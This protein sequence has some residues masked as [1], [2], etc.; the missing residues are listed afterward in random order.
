MWRT[1]FWLLFMRITNWRRA[2]TTDWR[3]RER[4]ISSEIMSILADHP[5]RHSNHPSFRPPRPFGFL[6]SSSCEGGVSGGNWHEFLAETDGFWHTSG[7][8]K[9]FRQCITWGDRGGIRFQLTFTRNCRLFRQ[10]QFMSSPRRSCSVPLLSYQDFAKTGR[11]SSSHQ[12]HL[13]P[14]GRQYRSYPTAM[15]AT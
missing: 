3:N 15:N 14:R 9:L 6:S 7:K 4:N 12:S 2:A 13:M 10:L 1:S 11:L 5:G 8:C